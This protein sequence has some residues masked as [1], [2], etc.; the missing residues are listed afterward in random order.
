MHDILFR[1]SENVGF[2]NKK[3]TSFFKKYIFFGE[4]SIKKSVKFILSRGNYPWTVKTYATISPFI[5]FFILKNIKKFKKQKKKFGVLKIIKKGSV[6]FWGPSK[7]GGPQNLGSPSKKKRVLMANL[8]TGFAI[9][10]R[11]PRSEIHDISF[12]KSETFGV[13]KSQSTGPRGPG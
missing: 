4:K 5:L 2:Q 13:R 10:T 6:K 7:M 11:F 8:E 1:K 3:W 12:R 9:N